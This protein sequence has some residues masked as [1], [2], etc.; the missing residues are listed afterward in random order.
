MRTT[1]TSLW[2][3]AYAPIFVTDNIQYYNRCFVLYL[4]ELWVISTKKYMEWFIKK[5]YCKNTTGIQ[6]KN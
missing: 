4:V 6:K 1:N 3:V 2:L 5:T